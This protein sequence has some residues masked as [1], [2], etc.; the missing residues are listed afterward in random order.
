MKP[1]TASV[2]ILA[3]SLAMIALLARGD[4]VAGAFTPPAVTH[5]HS[6]PCWHAE[7]PASQDQ[8]CSCGWA[9]HTAGVYGV[10][11][12]INGGNPGQ[13]GGGGGTPIAPAV[14]P[15]KP[16]I[17]KIKPALKLD[18]ARFPAARGC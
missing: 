15:V 7:A 13:P 9:G 4:A 16:A 1:S 6:C 3:T 8:L 18:C 17:T 5:S 12:T 11:C 2:S 14:K 10:E